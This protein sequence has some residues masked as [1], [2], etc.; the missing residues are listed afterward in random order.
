MCNNCCCQP[1]CSIYR[2]TGGV[3]NCIHFREERK[4]EWVKTGILGYLRCN[5]CN[6]VYICEEWLTD[7][8]WNVCPNCGAKMDGERRSDG[9]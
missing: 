3:K 2:A 1:V 8:K 7:G 5:R 9:N 4:G 6:D